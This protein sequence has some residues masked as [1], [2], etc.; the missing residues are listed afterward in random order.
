MFLFFHGGTCI[1]RILFTGSQKGPNHKTMRK[2]PHSFMVLISSLFMPV[3]LIALFIY[4]FIA[5]VFRQ[6][7]PHNIRYTK[8]VGCRIYILG[9]RAY[10]ISLLPY[11]IWEKYA[12]FDVEA[13]QRYAVC[14]TVGDVPPQFHLSYLT[15]FVRCESSSS[16]Q[17]YSKVRYTAASS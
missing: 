11:L 2:K 4:S 16:L 12:V 5:V 7:Y 15:A 6:S 17:L 10:R 8:N 13:H 9:W 14:N 1:Y 3:V